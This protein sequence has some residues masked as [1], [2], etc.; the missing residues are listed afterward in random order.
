LPPAHDGA[1]KLGFNAPLRYIDCRRGAEN[2][3][4]GG[5]DEEGWGRRC[6]LRG[7]LAGGDVMLGCGWVEAG[8]FGAGEGMRG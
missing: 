2:N 3:E 5:F 7:G 4:N 6:R 8:L 1:L